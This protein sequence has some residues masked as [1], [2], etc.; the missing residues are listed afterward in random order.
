[1]LFRSKIWM[2]HRDKI[3]SALSSSLLLR[4]LPAI[5]LSSEPFSED[6]IDELRKMASNLLRV[7]PEMTGYFVF[8]GEVSN[9][10]YAP[11]QGPIGIRMKG[12]GI[13]DISEVSDIFTHNMLS[14]DRIKYFLCYPKQ[15]RLT[16]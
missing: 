5:E 4:Q 15:I 13:R 3:L 2:D 7:A 1:M 8:S 6:R 14:Q 10:T 16:D 9:R 12:G 11:D